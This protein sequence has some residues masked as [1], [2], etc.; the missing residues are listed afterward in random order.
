[1]GCVL[2]GR[3][4]DL[5][6]EVAVKV[7][8]ETHAGR[9]ELLQR[10]I[11]EAQIAGQLQHPGV[12]P[13]YDLGRLSD[14]RPYFTMKLV[15]GQTLAHLLA[16][17]KE[18]AEERSRWL[19]VFLQAAQA[20]AYAH[21]RGV[22]HRDL[23]PGNIMV[24][25]YGE[26]QVMDWGLAKV[27]TRGG[28]A[29]DKASRGRES[30]EAASVIRTRR[31]SGSGGDGTQTQ[32]GSILGTPAYMAPEQAL[33]QVDHL[34]ERTDV[35]GL[36]SILCEILTGKPPYVGKGFTEVHR[37]A[38]RADLADAFARLDGCGADSEL[39]GLCKRCLAAEPEGRPSNAGAVAEEVSAYR[40]G[41]EER[42]RQA[43]LQRAQAEVKVAEE[44]KRRRVQL[45]LAVAL[46]ALLLLGGG[47]GLYVQQQHERRRIETAQ[48]YAEMRQAAEAA[49]DKAAELQRQSR[50][51]EAQ[52][53]LSQ[54]L[55]QLGELPAGESR[56]RL[57]TALA[58]AALV[59]ELDAARLKRATWIE[60][61]FDHAGAAQAYADV[62][63][64]RGLG[65]QGDDPEAV[66]ARV[67]DSAVK[68]QLLAALDD[69]AS[70]A[71]VA[72][73]PFAWPMQVAR[74][75]DPHPWRDRLRD[76]A[77]WRNRKQVRALT[78][79]AKEEDLTPQAALALGWL[80]DNAPA[81]ELLRRI[82]RRHPGDFWVNFMLGTILPREAQ[83]E[84]IGYLR[85]AVA[86]RPEASAALNNLGLALKEQG[87]VDEAAECYRKAL[88]SDPRN[89]VA[90]SNLGLC[91]C[92]EGKFDEAVAFHRR[93]LA[94]DPRYAPAHTSLGCV[95]E[96]Q[97]KLDEAIASHR[98]AI[99][100]NKRSVIAH[101]NLGVALKHKGQLDEAIQCCRR[102]LAIDPTYVLALN[103]LGGALHEKR[104]LDEAADCFRKA[105]GLAPR[106]ALAHTNLGVV[107]KDKGQLDEAVEC[108]R[109]ALEIDPRHAV[110]IHNLGETLMA[111]RKEDRAIEYFRKAIEI[112][113][114]DAHF[115][116]S[117]G[118]ALRR[119]GI[120]DEAIACFRGALEI[121]P[122]DARAHY[123]L[124][125][126]WCDKGLRHE[127]L[128]S[129]RKAIQ[130]DP[131]V[132][133]FHYNLGVALEEQ[134]KLDE[135][136]ACYRRAIELDP[137]FAMAH[138]NLGHALEA[139]GLPDEAILWY[140]KALECDPQL[141][142]AQLNLGAALYRKGQVAKAAGWFRKAVELEPGN[143]KAHYNLG[144][145]LKRQGKLD[146]AIACYREAIVLNPQHAAAHNNLGTT[147]FRKGKVDEAIACLRKAIQI[148]PHNANAHSNLGGALSVRGKWE[149]AIAH[150][151]QAITLN[152]RAG[153]YRYEAACSAAEAGCGMGVNAGMLTAQWRLALRRQALTWLRAELALLS[154]WLKVEP[155]RHA[156]GV[157]SALLHWQK[158]SHLAGLRDEGALERLTAEERQT[159]RKLWADVAG[160]LD[161]VKQS[162]RNE[163]N[164]P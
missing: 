138:N 110:A 114:Q 119:K 115:H 151:K 107:L 76:P 69:W 49:L 153:G 86:L 90:L 19:G 36:G 101:Y 78:A 41:V 70:S 74:R 44:R 89:V 130:I 155:S 164:R 51:P 18:S 133:N 3:D 55:E 5:G 48:R 40:Q 27:L 105:I 95:L 59:G 45:A 135:A 2:L 152:P 8:L 43:E 23:K 88:Q 57:E 7:L 147:L 118:A 139:R 71:W 73:R 77:L 42:L 113:P 148:E 121:D 100:L 68:E 122:R 9:T 162:S 160:L 53:L 98:R 142:Q 123:E 32:A 99:S 75:A 117:L 85:A 87:K 96:R 137:R 94:I 15:K 112:D 21:A 1:M 131:H 29:E 72:G 134:R 61:M 17:R 125:M 10:F 141:V 50:W 145:A 106:D 11:E 56:T 60:N 25:N 92:D 143:A 31:S 30:P 58:D 34:D 158:D 127:A 91:L 159:C 79:E 33:G 46:F 163:E 22:I 16:A 108:H 156:Q 38:V 6:R 28:S 132:A 84:A 136:I 64:R 111:E 47:G 129:F 154:E 37:K 102:A 66:A 103:N 39:I 26:V 116:S 35:F 52:M 67:R 146:D 126:C 157:L 161:K 128:A 14:R 12:V 80:R 4:A 63:Q 54:A 93:S 62:F 140:R 24:G 149:Q 120:V 65:A 97:G 20:L 13:V 144:N 109:R 124:G 83:G 104:Q 150:Y 82:H 81:V